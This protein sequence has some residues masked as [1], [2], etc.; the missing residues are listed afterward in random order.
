[1]A[2]FFVLFLNAYQANVVQVART[3]FSQV[4]LWLREKGG[5]GG[6]KE[7]KRFSFWPSYDCMNTFY[8]REASSG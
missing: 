4:W 7:K 6:E 3:R 8:I 1:M 5:G 2:L